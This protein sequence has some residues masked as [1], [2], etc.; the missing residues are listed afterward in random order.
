MQ[1]KSHIH[2]CV[3]P[4]IT[5][6]LAGNTEYNTVFEHAYSRFQRIKYYQRGGKHGNQTFVQNDILIILNNSKKIQFHKPV[7]LV[8]YFFF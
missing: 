6:A 8:S 1:D 7:K 4:T 5:N 2:G 3:C